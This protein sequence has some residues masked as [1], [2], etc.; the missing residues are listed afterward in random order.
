MKK[1]YSIFML[2]LFTLVLAACSSDSV[3]TAEGTSGSSKDLIVSHFLPSNHPF[4]QNIL[5]K[6][7]D[8]VSE[9]TDGRLTYEIFAANALGS[10]SS[11]YELA[12][13][14]GA[15]IS[16]S[17]HG[18]S[19]GRF[20]LTSI[21]ELPFAVDDPEEGA[22]VLMTLLDE[23]PELQEEHG[24]TTVLW[25]YTVE[26]AQI[27][28]NKKVEKPEDLKG[29]KVRT[30]SQT[31]SKMIESVGGT[32]VSMSMSEVYD[33][34]SKGVIDAALVPRGELK[35]YNFYE[36][37]DYVTLG[38]FSSTPFYVTMNTAAFESLSV[39]DQEVLKNNAEKIMTELSD[40]IVTEG[41][42][43]EKVARENGVEIIE[44]TDEQFSEW[45]KAFEPS[46]QQW[47]QEREAEGLPGQAMYDRLKELTKD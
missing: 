6:Y 37:V 15:D 38:N 26:P 31:A 32:P 9:E 14:G 28:S 30:P 8:R 33:S 5:K 3:K 21:V 13:T 39:E 10:P 45:E 43:G 27:L 35:D 18:F 40:A 23:F 17:V 22:D 7:L 16:M 19:S 29:L 42:A 20:P 2:A 11:H 34:L 25:L 4:E 1:F 12:A 41:E 44:L 47:I 46:V 24:D 36:V